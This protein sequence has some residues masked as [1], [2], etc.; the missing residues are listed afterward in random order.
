MAI[1]LH[2][3]QRR[4]SLYKKN[5]AQLARFNQQLDL[6]SS[7][8]KD[9]EYANKIIQHTHG[10]LICKVTIQSIDPSLKSF[11]HMEMVASFEGRKILQLNVISYDNA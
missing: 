6:I 2:V 4:L 8:L 5:M 1:Y 11:T 10:E 7:L 9:S 3:S